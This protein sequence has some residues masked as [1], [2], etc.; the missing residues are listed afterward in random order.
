MPSVKTVS[1]SEFARKSRVLL[2]RAQHTGEPLLLTRRGK[3]VARVV[4][5]VSA[6]TP[7]ADR[8]PGKSRLGRW[9][10]RMEI[11]GDIVS[12]LPIEDWGSL[13]G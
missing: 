4:P 6:S 8:K 11:R 3:P 9:K 7:K 12:P 1:I 2:A 5:A 10:G 13:G